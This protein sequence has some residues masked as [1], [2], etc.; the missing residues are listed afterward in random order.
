MEPLVTADELR[1]AQAEIATQLGDPVGTRDGTDL[2]EIVRV[3]LRSTAGNALY[4]VPTRRA[5]ILTRTLLLRRCF[6]SC[7]RRVAVVAAR[8]WMEREGYYMICSEEDLV[9]TVDALADLHLPEQ[10]FTAWLSR[11]FRRLTGPH[12]GADPGVRRI[13]SRADWNPEKGS[14]PPKFLL[15]RPDPINKKRKG[16]GLGFF[17]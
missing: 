10:R 17:E 11:N 14:F 16:F 5:S 12:P 3:P 15:G 2:D 1:V 6:R 8:S 9:S 4:E 7:N 13:A